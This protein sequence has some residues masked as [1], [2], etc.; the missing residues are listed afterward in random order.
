MDYA[1]GKVSDVKVRFGGPP[2]EWS[3]NPKRTLCLLDKVATLTLA[4]EVCVSVPIEGMDSPD[5]RPVVQCFCEQRTIS[6]NRKMLLYT[7]VC[8]IKPVVA[9]T[10]SWVATAN[11]GSL[12]I[13]DTPIHDAIGVRPVGCEPSPQVHLPNCRVIDGDKN[14]ERIM[15]FI[16]AP[17]T[18]LLQDLWGGSTQIELKRGLW[19]CVIPLGVWHTFDI[20]EAGAVFFEQRATPYDG[21]VGLTLRTE[22][23]WKEA[24]SVFRSVNYD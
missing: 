22:D 10:M 24:K 13:Q 1:F 15:L 21:Q 6:P 2:V 14:P 8:N 9:P 3:Q 17:G 4:R 23:E 20:R 19:R 11:M 7:V 5:W 18:L 16:S 12:Q